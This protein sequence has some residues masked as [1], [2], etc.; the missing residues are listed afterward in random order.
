MG[1]M[2]SVAV[3]ISVVRYEDEEVVLEEMDEDVPMFESNPLQ[4]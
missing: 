3:E 1:L 4:C 2:G